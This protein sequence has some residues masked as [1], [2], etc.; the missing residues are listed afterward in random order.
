MRLVTVDVES[1]RTLAFRF[2]LPIILNSCSCTSLH[3]ILGA[4]LIPGY[5]PIGALVRKI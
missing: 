2:N 5:G 1:Q 3:I 4:A